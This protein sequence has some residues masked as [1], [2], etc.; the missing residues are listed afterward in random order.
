M[1]HAK[2]FMILAIIILALVALILALE[3]IRGH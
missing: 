2:Q 1:R 3:N